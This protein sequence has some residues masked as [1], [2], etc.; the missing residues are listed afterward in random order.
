MFGGLFTCVGR[1]VSQ[2]VG[3]PVGRS[4]GW[5]VVS[6]VVRLV[7]WLVRSLGG[8]CVSLF[9]SLLVCVMFVR[10]LLRLCV[11]FSCCLFVCW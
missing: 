5:L 9:V 6:S 7:G 8:W 10:F 1:L 11:F 4:V 3:G 2:V